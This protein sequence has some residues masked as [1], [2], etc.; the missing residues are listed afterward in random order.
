MKRFNKIIVVSALSTSLLA[1]S[2]Y[3]SNTTTDTLTGDTGFIAPLSLATTT[4]PV[5]GKLVAG[6]GSTSSYA[7]ATNGIITPSSS[8]APLLSGTPVAGSVLVKGSANQ[9]VT[10]K[11]QNAVASGGV[12]ITDVQ[13][14]YG[15]SAPANCFSTAINPTSA[16][17]S[18]GTTLLIGP[19]INVPASQAE[20]A[21]TPTVDIVVAY[22]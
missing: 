16:P 18:A 9:L 10:V 5:F 13:C 14:K 12:T 8:G 4:S 19:T 17:T 6:L 2:A 3:A 21:I 15:A 22:Q 1:I 20:G 7:M 11:A